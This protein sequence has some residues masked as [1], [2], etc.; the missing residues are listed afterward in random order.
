[1]ST[2]P[3]PPAE[4]MPAF[5]HIDGAA[6]RWKKAQKAPK[7]TQEQKD[8]QLLQRMH[9]VIGPIDRLRSTGITFGDLMDG[10]GRI[11]F[12]FP[13]AAVRDARAAVDRLIA[14][15]GEE[16]LLAD[17]NGST[18]ALSGWREEVAALEAEGMKAQR[19][20]NAWCNETAAAETEER[21]R[22]HKLKKSNGGK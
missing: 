7:P 18:L 9:H 2:E 4:L 10:V 21:A 8:A 19:L 20:I 1:M 11:G 22:A 6:D 16:H 13:A 17:N 14:T 12:G 3:Q 5:A 15:H